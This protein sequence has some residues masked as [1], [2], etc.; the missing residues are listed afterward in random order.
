MTTVILTAIGLVLGSFINAFVYR[1][2][3]EKNWISDRSECVNCHHKLNIFDLVPI[4]SYLFLRGQ[5]HYCHKKISIQYP[6]VEILTALLF[7]LS[8]VYWPH[9]IQ[10]IELVVF[11]DWLILLVGLI[12]LAIYDIK[13]MILP[14]KILLFYGFFAFIYA[15]L[16][17]F[18][19]YDFHLSNLLGYIYSVLVSSGLF[20]SLF[21][22]SKGK[23]IGG[24]DV[25]L[26]LMLGLI[27]G[28][29]EKAVL[30]IFLSSLIGSILS[31]ILVGL[32]R[33][34]IKKTIPYGPFLIL[35]I[36]I[37]VLWGDKIVH[38]YNHFLV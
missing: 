35:S 2:H 34:N 18:F 9:K 23:W 37:I 17:I 32:G 14:N 28:T 19:I 25:K 20:Y 15:V 7:L 16:N 22:A 11:I 1:Y 29:F 13:W 10:G 33:L 31:I 30:L 21:T 27:A 4:L 26:G 38:W 12:S 3:E 24:G 6:V 5:C 36:Y 8:Y